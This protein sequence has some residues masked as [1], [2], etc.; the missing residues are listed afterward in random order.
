MTETSKKRFSIYYNRNPILSKK[1][2]PSDNL[3]SV[4]KILEGKISCSFYFSLKDTP[5]DEDDEE[6]TNIS[7]IAEDSDKIYTIPKK[8]QLLLVSNSSENS[9]EKNSLSEES[10]E[11]NLVE[12]LN[13][14]EPES[15]KNTSPDLKKE[16]TKIIQEKNIIS[17]NGNN[18]YGNNVDF[19]SKL[20]P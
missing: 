15:I 6:E 11:E 2:V 17:V 18:R 16:D 8:T 13:I 10:K 4:R 19:S 12:C 3:K 20:F 9:D 1:L 7:E 5:I 14:T